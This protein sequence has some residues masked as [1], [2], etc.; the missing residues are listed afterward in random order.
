M[1]SARAARQV[2][3][4]DVEVVTIDVSREHDPSRDIERRTGIRDASP[5]AVLID[6]GVAVWS[7]SHSSID[8]SSIERALKSSVAIR[9]QVRAVVD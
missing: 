6:K 7:A 4:V 2:A 1:T 8:R 5:Q 9:R 3:K